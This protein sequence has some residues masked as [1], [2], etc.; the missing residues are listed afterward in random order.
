MVKR[1]HFHDGAARFELIG[2][3]DDGHHHHLVCVNCS[4]V[5]EI[6][7]CFPTEIEERIA[8]KNGF[9]NV[10]HK[11]ELFGTCPECQG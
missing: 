3:G 6:A 2:E 1:Y 10:T 8:E 9:K 7:E 11:L 4:G 5:V